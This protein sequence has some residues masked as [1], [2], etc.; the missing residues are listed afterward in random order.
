M[1]VL[2]DRVLLSRSGITRLI[3]RLVADG[4]VERLACATDARGAEALL[5]DA[6]LERL[7]KAAATHLR[8]I[9]EHF[10]EPVEPADIAGLERA[11]AAIVEAIERT[12]GRA[13]ARAG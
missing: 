5:T 10:F 9:A 7:R 1:H 11:T 12:E 4:A 13:R 3:D 2:A 8:G 6:G